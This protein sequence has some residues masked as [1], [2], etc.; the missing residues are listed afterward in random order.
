MQEKQFEAQSRMLVK[1]PEYCRIECRAGF[2]SLGDKDDSELTPM[3]MPAW[4]LDRRLMQLL[5]K[6]ARFAGNWERC[7]CRDCFG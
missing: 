4:P 6:D 5:P 2:L 7:A 3:E 1:N